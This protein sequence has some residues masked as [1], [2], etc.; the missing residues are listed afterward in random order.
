MTADKFILNKEDTVLLIIDIQ[1][2]LAAVMKERDK[3]I[4]N[5][6]NMISSAMPP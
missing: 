4:K 3:V 2:K 1:D 6:L 5:N